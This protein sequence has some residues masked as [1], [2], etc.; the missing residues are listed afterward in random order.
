MI[1]A[2]EF[3]APGQPPLV[4]AYDAVAGGLLTLDGT[5][6]VISTGTAPAPA[7]PPPL[8]ASSVTPDAAEAK[9]LSVPIEKYSQTLVPGEAYYLADD[10]RTEGDWV[11]RYGSGYAKLCGMAEGDQDYDLQPGYEVR[12]Q[13]GPHHEENAV[14][15]VS[16]HDDETS[17]DLRSLYDPTLG[18]RRD[19]QENDFSENTK[20]YP[21]TYNGPDL[22]V[23]VKVPDGVHCVSLYFVNND[24]HTNSESKYRDYDVQIVPGYPDDDKAAAATPLARTRVTDFWGGVYKQFLVCGPASYVVRIGR[25]RSYGT[26]LQ[27]VFLDPVTN[28]LTETPGQLPGFAAAPYS[29][30]AEP[31]DYHPTPLTDAAVTLWNRLDDSLG[32]RG[33]I[34]FQ[35]PLRIWCYRAAIAGGAPAELLERW[36]WQIAIWKPEDRR[37]FDGAMKAAFGALK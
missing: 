29:V 2:I 35:M 27:G 13:V 26:R 22:W 28:D 33:A 11:G 9:V 30:P 20:I 6:P 10:W 25:N 19:A 36:R 8:P 24:A 12:L 37:K 14:G 17:D 7:Q 1:R 31:E 18:H 15:P 4:A 32:L 5:Q 3:P 16:Y 23:R 34:P 21:E